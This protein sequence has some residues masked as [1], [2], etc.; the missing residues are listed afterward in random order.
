MARLD[1]PEQVAH[2]LGKDPCVGCNHF[3]YC[4]H[5]FACRSFMSYH[6]SGKYNTDAPRYPSR[7]IYL[8]IE[9]DK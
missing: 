5:G 9:K 8:M 2:L 4:R 7:E 6:R 3:N 1:F